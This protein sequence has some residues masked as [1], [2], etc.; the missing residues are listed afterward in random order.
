M[1]VT[2]YSILTAIGFI[3]G[4]AFAEARAIPVEA[5]G[6]MISIA[7]AAIGVSGLNGMREEVEQ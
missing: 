1:R 4:A 5:I 7:V 2:V 6:L 3:G